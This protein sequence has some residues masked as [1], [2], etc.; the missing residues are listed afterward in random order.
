M[1]KI[2]IFT[3]IALVFALIS[4]DNG[5][6]QGDGTSPHTHE[7]GAWQS[8]ATQHWKE[9]TANDGAEYGRANHT[10]NPCNVCG[11]EEIP[12]VPQP[13]II[14]NTNGLAFDGKVTIKTSDLYTAADWDAVV[15]NVITAFN[16]AYEGATIKLGFDTA[17]GGNG[18]Q[19]VLVNN[20]PTNWEVKE[21]LPKDTGVYGTLYIRASSINS[22]A[23]SSY[24]AAMMAVSL[25]N[26]A[27]SVTNAAPPQRGAVLATVSDTKIGSYALG[28]AAI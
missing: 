24:E 17:F 23:G 28:S 22:I 21:T 18:L 8:N 16:A 27:T 9:C 3:I 1:K 4:C 6:D 11:Y 5:N 19:I 2:I 7:W 10:G 12:T 20:L 26:P 15:A 14:D 13:K 25:N